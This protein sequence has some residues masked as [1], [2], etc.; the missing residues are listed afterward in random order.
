MNMYIYIYDSGGAVGR[1]KDFDL[2]EGD[3]GK[4]KSHSP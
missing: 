3:S 1:R 4:H 2:E